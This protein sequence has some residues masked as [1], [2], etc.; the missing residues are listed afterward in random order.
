MHFDCVKN[1]KVRVWV[2]SDDDYNPRRQGTMYA[3]HRN[4]VRPQA[5]SLGGQHLLLERHPVESSKR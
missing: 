2:V 5:A 3:Y 1:R 4:T